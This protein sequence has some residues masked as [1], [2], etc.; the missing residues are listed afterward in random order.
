MTN[1]S[2]EEYLTG[3]RIATEANNAYRG[4]E[5]ESS[6]TDEQYD[7]LVAQLQQLGETN[8]WS[9]HVDLV[10]KVSGGAGDGSGT[11]DVKHRTRMLS[12]AKA[13][14]EEELEKFLSRVR[15]LKTPLLL[16]PKLD[17]LAI[18]AS[19]LNGQLV[20]VSTR[21][22]SRNGQDV[23]ARAREATITGL[24]KTIPFKGDLEVRGELFLTRSAFESAQKF[25]AKH[26]R[27]EY[28]NPRN[29]VSGAILSKDIT[30]LE[31]LKMSYAVY[32]Y[33]I[34]SPANTEDEYHKLMKEAEANGF[35]PA[36][37][38][39]PSLQG[40]TVMEKVKSFGELRNQI[41]IPTDGI[42][43]KVNSFAVRE[44]LGSGERHPHWAIAYKFEAE[45]KPTTLLSITRDV[46]R[47]GAISYTAN[48]NP[49]ELSES[50]VSNATLNNAR[51]IELMDL[52]IGDVVM[53][54]KA[55]EIIPEIV[56]VDFSARAG[57]TLP[58][59]NAPTTC[60]N[61]EETLDT[62][63]S[64]VW[65]CMNPG[66]AQAPTI[67]YAV[68]R[69]NLDIDGLSTQLVELLLEAG[70]IND[71]TDL[72]T[73]TVDRL[74]NLPTGRVNKDGQ[75]IVVGTT[76]AEKLVQQIQKSKNQP[77]N[78]ILSSL[79]VRFMGRTFGRRF[80]SHFKS[81][82]AAVNAT[83][84]QMQQVEGVKEKAVVIR[85]ELDKRQELLN[86]Y[87]KVGFTQ[88]NMTTQ[89]TKDSAGSLKL[90]G[91]NVVIT[92][93]VPG[94]SRNEAKEL[95]ETHGGVAGSSV[96][97][98]TTLLV[99]P[100]EERDTSKAKKATELGVRIITPEQFLAA[101]R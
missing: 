79:G 57:K 94:Y 101:L 84:Q 19:Y 82:D 99:A 92:G 95:I 61:C 83:V 37:S 38:L 24:P 9:E 48:L 12:L 35:C 3:I 45:I 85:A 87:R 51:F 65:R 80:A 28:K 2:R 47:T 7:L 60:P 33:I 30:R 42:V 27:A 21:G 64:V 41:G 32:D 100:A 69:D 50:T 67:I 56:G 40:D 59:Y 74:A 90:A 98:K 81:F 52:R 93:T 26:G 10:E 97:S 39:L 1:P 66:C 23:T 22:D 68:N 62:T 88:M 91:Q 11:T 25:R 8:G 58:R 20:Q 86:K 46:G 13:Q 78:R 34:Y 36:S 5:E 15:A 77:L 53:V 4:G 70:Y 29:A 54:R 14:N 75:M 17:G 72:Y 76:V 18:N 96:S 55:N 73:L 43:L 44:Q 16:E 31:G 63:S 89:N 6:L 49:V 71:V